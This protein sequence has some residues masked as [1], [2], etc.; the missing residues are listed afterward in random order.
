MFPWC[1]RTCKDW[2]WRTL[3]DKTRVWYKYDRTIHQCPFFTLICH[4]SSPLPSSAAA[5]CLNAINSFLGFITK[6]GLLVN[7]LS[8]LRCLALRCGKGHFLIFFNGSSSTV[9]WYLMPCHLDNEHATILFLKSVFHFIS[10]FF[11][12]LSYFMSDPGSTSLYNDSAKFYSSKWL[13][14]SKSCHS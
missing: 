7:V 8:V 12:L 1:V 3:K 6:R 9:H 4:L 14:S 10:V 13:A 5:F 11:F 2:I